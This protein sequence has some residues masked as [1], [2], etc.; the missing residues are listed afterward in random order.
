MQTPF[1]AYDGDDDFVFCCY[2][3]QDVGLVYP[4]IDQLNS[5]DMNIWYDEGIRPG[6]EWTDELANAIR[7][8]SALILFATSR[9]VHS[10]HCR[11]EVQYATKYDKPIIVIYLEPT[12][13]PPG[14]DLTL[15]GLHAIEKGTHTKKR[16]IQL[17]LD[18]IRESQLGDTPKSGQPHTPSAPRS[19][20]K[21]NFLK[22]FQ[23]AGVGISLIALVSAITFVIFK[24]EPAEPVTPLKAETKPATNTVALIPFENRG[25]FEEDSYYPESLSEDLLN[26]LVT[27]DGISVASRRSSFTFGQTAAPKLSLT[28][29]AEKLG[30]AS[31]VVGYIR[32]S[33]ESIRLSL[34]LIDVSS[35]TEVV[36]WSNSYDN[37]ALS[38]MLAIQADAT[39]QIARAFFPD[40]ISAATIERLARVSTNSPQAYK[41]YLQAKELLRIPLSD[42]SPMETAVDLFSQALELDP[43]YAWAKAGL[44]NAYRLAYRRNPGEFANVRDACEALVDYEGD[45]F[46]VR[47]AL[48]SYYKEI[49]EVGLAYT[50]LSIAEELNNKS[51]DAK[52]RFGEILARRFL[53]TKNELD[54]IRAEQA[55]LEAIEAAPSYW[56]SYHVYATFLTNESRFDEAIAMLD[57]AL[58]REPDS[59][60]TLNN[61]A[62]VQ[63][64]LGLTDTAEENWLKSL[65]ISQNNRF[66]Y[67]GLGVLYHYKGEFESAAEMYRLAN[68]LSASD[69]ETLGRLGESLRL[70]P[71]R[72]E[73]AV[74]VFSRALELVEER[75]SIN[76]TDW[77]AR[78]LQ[79]LYYAYVGKPAEA[80]SSLQEMYR[81]NKVNEPM[82]HYWEALI[83]YEQEDIERTFVQI[84]LALAAGFDKEKQFFIDEPALAGLRESHGRR[85]DEL[86]SRY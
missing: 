35:G 50:E 6:S 43:D 22:R 30:V 23:S 4:E 21:P 46:E 40:G 26:R 41:L 20:G 42:T 51:P 47:L 60:S 48:G 73:E 12:D 75:I 72:K 17:I 57:Q 39:T 71:A 63:Y 61:L 27:I 31:L 28:D 5:A 1:A 81:L 78:G 58:L 80:N 76:P 34:E 3:H 74:Q 59:I 29:I 66:A 70:I 44:C 83:A 14:L 82:T 67:I 62:N 36:R 54:R 79:A 13:L 68:Q 15:G 52:L 16:Y 33:G 32:R 49:G 65:S 45:L 38:N 7:N 10:K 69:Y 19:F 85:F 25:G 55:F 9:S 37:Q 84:D 18:A 86:M 53:Q 77:H 56:F 8:C 64:R 11:D 24:Q 2:S